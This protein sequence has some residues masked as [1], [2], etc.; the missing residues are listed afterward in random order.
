VLKETPNDE[1]SHSSSKR[2]ASED[3]SRFDLVP[4][5]MIVMCLRALLGKCAFHGKR[6]D[7]VPERG[8]SQDSSAGPR[9][10]TK[11]ENYTCNVSRA[12][13]NTQ[14][15]ASTVL[16]FEIDNNSFATVLELCQR[17]DLD[18]VLKRRNAC[19]RD[20]RAVLQICWVCST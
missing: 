14:R 20:A 3:S 7:L 10:P 2:V 18:V 13:T 6:N 4:S 11:K 12:N 16:R 9:G 5:Y 19:R 15:S 8:G 17:T 1:M